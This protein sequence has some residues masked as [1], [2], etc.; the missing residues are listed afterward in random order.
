MDFSY[1]EEQTLLRDSVARFLADNYAFE[2]FKTISRG[3]P[4]W[5]PAIW[6]QFAELGLLGASLPEDFGGLGG[7]PIETMVVMEEFGKALVGEPYVPTVVI[8]GG[9]LRQ[10]GSDAQKQEWLP[11]IAS[12]DAVM[13]FAFAEPQARYS[14]AD[15]TT[16]A[17]KQS[18]SYILSG[19][20]TVVLGGPSAD[21]LIVTART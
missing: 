16:A 8:G 3:E 19:Q 11:K 2:A 20:K 7:G 13:A 6:K 12:G 1:T 17:K 14:L 15:L 4:G 10:A 5:R 9:L 21:M 18:G